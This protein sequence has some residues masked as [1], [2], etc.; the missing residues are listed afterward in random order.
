MLFNCDLGW[1]LSRRRRGARFTLAVD[2]RG[3]LEDEVFIVFPAGDIRV[4]RAVLVDDA[5]DLTI[6][7][8]EVVHGADL[9]AEEVILCVD[10]SVRNAHA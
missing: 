5:L 10:V 9:V 8:V 7:C 1:S 4:V 6:G 3:D 2:C